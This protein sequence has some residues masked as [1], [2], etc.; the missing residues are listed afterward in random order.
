MTDSK[1]SFFKQLMTK[2][3]WNKKKNVNRVYN[4]DKL[5]SVQTVNRPVFDMSK[6]EKDREGRNLTVWVT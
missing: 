5:K 4:R 6:Y 3:E 1:L 2:L